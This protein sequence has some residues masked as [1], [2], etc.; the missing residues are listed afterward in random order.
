MTDYSGRAM[1]VQSENWIEMAKISRENFY[2]RRAVEWKL[3]FGLW[4]GIG[5]F[6]AAFFTSG[7]TNIPDWLPLTLACVYGGLLLVVIFCWQW[8]MHTAHADDHNWF[9]HYMDLAQEIPPDQA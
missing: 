9:V 3:A 8:P 5:L 1:P 6:T 2:N 7:V 4:T